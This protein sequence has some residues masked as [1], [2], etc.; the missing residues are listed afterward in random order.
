MA[1]LFGG[2]GDFFLRRL[3]GFA[4]ESQAVGNQGFKRLGAL[5]LGFGHGAQTCQPNVL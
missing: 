5:R 4:L 2:F 3:M 1:Q